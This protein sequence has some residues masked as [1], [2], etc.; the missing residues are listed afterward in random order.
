MEE[1]STVPGSNV[2]SAPLLNLPSEILIIIASLLDVS[3]IV[4][5]RRVRTISRKI[6]CNLRN[7]PNV[8]VQIFVSSL[9]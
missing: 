4:A 5:I 2:T 1:A 8:D 6:I 9:T 7:S 3:T